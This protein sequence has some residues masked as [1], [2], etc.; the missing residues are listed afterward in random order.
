MDQTTAP[1]D[2]PALTARMQ[3]MW[4]S[5]DFTEL[6]RQTIP[7][8]E[9]L[10]EA[11]DPHSGQRVL[12]VACGSGNAALAAARRYCEVTG[13]DYVPAI[14]ERARRRADAEGA[15]IDFRVADAQNLP[16]PDA[17]FDAVLS[18]F[19]VIFAPDQEKAA[20][21]MLRVCRPGGR[22]GLCTWPP[23]GLVADTFRAQSR[24]APPPPPGV[25]PPARWGTPEG[26][27]ELLGDKVSGLNIER[28]VFRSY[29]P[30]IEHNMAV[31]RKHLGPLSRTFQHLDT[32]DQDGL[33]RDLVAIFARYN[34]AT[35]GTVIQ[36][37][38]YLLVT[39][40]RK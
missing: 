39:A 32:A 9:A 28:R 2:F 19:G 26:L 24:F 23:E 29:H 36:D 20:G 4:A 5:G 16:F 27:S 30:S 15:S 3:A 21:E 8:T 12:D 38:N 17:S 37:M 40:T 18:A 33:S 10:V 25:K 13:I 6:G 11:V 35:D 34:H 1:L 22:I 7:A 14:I 31:L